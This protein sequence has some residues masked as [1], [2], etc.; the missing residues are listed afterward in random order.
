M[1][2]PING[3]P[4]PMGSCISCLTLVRVWESIHIR[5]SFLRLWYQYKY[6]ST[7][8][9]WFILSAASSIF[10]M[11]RL[12]AVMISVPN[13]R[14][15]GAGLKTRL[16]H[17][18]FILMCCWYNDGRPLRISSQIVIRMSSEFSLIQN[19]ILKHSIKYNVFK[20]IMI[21]FLS[22]FCTQVVS[23]GKIVRICKEI[24]NRICKEIT[25]IMC[26][27]CASSA[28]N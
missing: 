6:Q 27:T 15:V 28:R 9:E 12:S 10:F 1:V 8:C 14:R 20:K 16:R 25:A 2:T 4:L 18:W 19:Y 11:S 13:S 22:I 26:V 5:N 24:A 21:R 23:R 7:I 3:Y 17:G